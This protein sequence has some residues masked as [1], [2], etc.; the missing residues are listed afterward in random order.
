MMSKYINKLLTSAFVGCGIAAVL[1][2]CRFEDEDYFDQPAALRIEQ[3]TAEIQKTLV[4]APNGWVMQYFTGTDDIEGF[5]I[6]ARFDQNGKVT[7]AGNHRFLRDGNANKYTEFSSLYQLLREDGPVLAFNTWNDIL[8]PLV[9]PVDPSA[10]PGSLVKDGEGMAG[11]HNLVVLSYSND[12]ILLRGERHSARIRM[13]PCTGD[14]QEYFN[15]TN[16]FKDFAANTAITNFYVI[17]PKADTL[18][19]KNLRS[20]VVTYCERINDPLFPTTVNCLFTPN[21]FRL[22]REDEINGTKFQEFRLSADSICLLSENDSVRV[23]PCW[24][25]YI[26]DDIN[27]KKNKLWAFDSSTFNT[28]QKATYDAI[29]ADMSGLE[30]KGIGFYS[31]NGS[32]ASLTLEFLSGKKSV[33]ASIQFGVRKLGY[34]RVEMTYD[35]M[36]KANSNFNPLVKQGRTNVE[37]LMR[38]LAATLVGTYDLTPNSYFMP[39]GF[40]MKSV[41]GAVTYKLNN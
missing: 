36:G 17:G 12:E 20:G 13:I 1:T 39:T 25:N 11:D 6:M 16:T 41:D 22:H 14:W 37:P 5:N 21:G 10:A 3:T 27:K 24:D 40:M 34:G 31:Y 2:S 35:P 7:M 28:S 32:A 18:Y 30:V 19:F 23:F 8:M 4:D 29:L 15:A 33:Y 26:V 38:E 9:D